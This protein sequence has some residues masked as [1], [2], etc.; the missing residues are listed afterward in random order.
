VPGVVQVTLASAD[1]DGEPCIV[2]KLSTED[3]RTLAG[4]ICDLAEA[5][6]RTQD[7]W[8]GTADVAR[9]LNVTSSTIR[10]GLTRSL[11][12]DNPFP[13]PWKEQGKNQWR[14]S[15]IEAWREREQKRTVND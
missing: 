10:S 9:E 2:I 3:A 8:I 7:K 6:D 15:E 1:G 4:S 5:R 11:P 12:P 13:R 14:M